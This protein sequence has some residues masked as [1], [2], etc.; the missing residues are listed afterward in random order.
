MANIGEFDS[1]NVPPR[2]ASDP[3]PPGE[4]KAM[5]E[6]SDVKP[7]KK[8]DGYVLKLT[9]LVLEGPYSARKIFQNINLDNPNSKAVEIGQQEL[10]AVCHG[11]GKLKVQD[12]SELHNIP[13][14]IRVKIRPAKGDYPA[15]NEIAA[16]KLANGQ[17]APATTQHQRTAPAPGQQQAPQQSA[18]NTPPWLRKK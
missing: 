2:E 16:V 17:S 15:S 13:C 18:P 3:I 5:I 1:T 12:S 11:C 7:T 4:Y 6:E 8:N 14:V 9:W 10:S